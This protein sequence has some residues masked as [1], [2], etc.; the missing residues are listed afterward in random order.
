M[1]RKRS[2]ML[3]RTEVMERQIECVRRGRGEPLEDLR[4]AA[5]TAFVGSIFA[6]GMLQK[7]RGKVL[8]EGFVELTET[9]RAS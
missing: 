7:W 6:I 5:F 2:T 1:R 8:I 3:T 4:H 9:E